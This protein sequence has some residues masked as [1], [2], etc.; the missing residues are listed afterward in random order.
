MHHYFLFCEKALRPK[1]EAAALQRGGWCNLEDFIWA[2]ADKT[3]ENKI[4]LRKLNELKKVSVCVC[5]HVCLWVLSRGR[6]RSDLTLH[7]RINLHPTPN[8][9]HEAHNRLRN[10]KAH[11]EF[12]LKVYHELYMIIFHNSSI[13]SYKFLLRLVTGKQCRTT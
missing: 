3:E 2:W 5:A 6:E 12:I 11:P 13:S 9:C 7:L 1:K 4:H 8:C 10:K